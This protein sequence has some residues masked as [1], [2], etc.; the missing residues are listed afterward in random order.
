MRVGR[1]A[2]LPR[3]GHDSLFLVPSSSFSSLLL[4]SMELTDTKK[5]TSLK[6]EPALEPLHMW[7]PTSPVQVCQAPYKC[8]LVTPRLFDYLFWS[9]YIVIV[10]TLQVFEEGC[11]SLYKRVG[12]TRPSHH[13]YLRTFR[14]G[15][16]AFLLYHV[17]LQLCCSPRKCCSLSKRVQVHLA[18]L[19]SPLFVFRSTHASLEQCKSFTGRSF[20]LVPST[21]SPKS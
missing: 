11:T 3:D 16:D 18:I 20:L 1:H 9:P 2:G 17:S 8:A 4:S 12:R 21:L 10:T 19:E 15:Y 5:S 7:C 13:N 14:D 6:Y